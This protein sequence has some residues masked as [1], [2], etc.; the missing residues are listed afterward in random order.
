MRKKA[1]SQGLMELGMAHT[2]RKGKLRA[3]KLN[4][5][6]LWAEGFILKQHQ[7]KQA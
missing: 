1:T 2:R 7:N 4:E 3:V 6:W 5:A